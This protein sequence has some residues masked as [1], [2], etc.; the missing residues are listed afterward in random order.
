M[1]MLDKILNRGKTTATE[2]QTTAGEY[3]TKAGEYIPASLEKV[4]GQL[5]A[6]GSEALDKATQV[7]KEHPKLIGGIAMLLGAAVLAGMKKRGTF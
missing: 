2:V 6:R 7:Y 5:K 3:A 1:T 4:G